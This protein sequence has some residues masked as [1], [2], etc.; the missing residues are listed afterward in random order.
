MIAT[1]IT[2]YVKV[3]TDLHVPDISTQ[4]VTDPLRFRRLYNVLLGSAPLTRPR[5]RRT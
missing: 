5:A 2:R 3:N 1:K 4:P